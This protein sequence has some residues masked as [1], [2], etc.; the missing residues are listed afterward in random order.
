M[1]IFDG[2]SYEVEY[3]RYTGWPP[4]A[5]YIV[6][7]NTGLSDEPIFHSISVEGNTVSIFYDADGEVLYAES[8]DGGG[9]FD[10]DV[11]LGGGGGSGGCAYSHIRHDPYTNS[12]VAAY[13]ELESGDYNIYVRIKS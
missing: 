7:L 8:I 12:I 10:P 11:V 3:F 6:S 2:T 5:P 13:A 9:N 4:T 1:G